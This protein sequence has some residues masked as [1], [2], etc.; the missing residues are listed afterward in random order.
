MTK[1]TTKRVVVLSDETLKIAK[2]AIESTWEIEAYDEQRE[3]HA[4]T[5]A[6]RELRAALDQPQGGERVVT[7]YQ[8]AG[9]RVGWRGPVRIFP[10]TEH[11]QAARDDLASFDHSDSAYSNVRILEQTTITGPWQDID[12]QE[13]VSNQRPL[14]C[15][16]SHGENPDHLRPS[17]P[18]W[19]PDFGEP[20]SY[21]SPLPRPSSRSDVRKSFGGNR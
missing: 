5:V 17:C 10:A 7:V 19:N 4:A 13:G 1:E 14:A 16:A 15:E 12:Q 8:V 21:R 3:P 9:D 2:L 18:P 11:L 6:W 20:R